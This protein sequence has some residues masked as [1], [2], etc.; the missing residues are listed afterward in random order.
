MVDVDGE[1]AVAV[2]VGGDGDAQFVYRFP[3]LSQEVDLVRVCFKGLPTGATAVLLIP[4]L[5][6]GDSV[7]HLA[8]RHTITYT[9]DSNQELRAL[10]D[11]PAGVQVVILMPL[12]TKKFLGERV[13]DHLLKSHKLTVADVF[14]GIY[15]Q[16]GKLPCSLSTFGM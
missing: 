9:H 13:V 15:S 1:C 8:S 11:P 10:G 12:A 14:A 4:F 2:D 6:G 3:C 5:R 16:S 7:A